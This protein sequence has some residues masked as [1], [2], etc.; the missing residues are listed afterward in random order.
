MN[1]YVH[2]YNTRHDAEDPF[3]GL[4]AR[5]PRLTRR[6]AQVELEGTSNGL[7]DRSIFRLRSFADLSVHFWRHP[8]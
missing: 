8:H 4:L 1:E 2:R 6:G 3:F 7:R 5:A